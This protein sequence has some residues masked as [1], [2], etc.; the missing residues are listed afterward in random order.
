ML[1]IAEFKPTAPFNV[2]MLLLFPT[3]ET[4]N[5]VRT[6]KYDESISV[7]FNGSFQT[8]GGTE[9]NVNGIYSIEDTANIT[10]WYMPE[11]KSNCRIKVLPT[12]AEYDIV[13]EPE[14]INLRNQYLKFKVKR[15]KGYA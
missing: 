11:I 7:L 1:K 4:V 14:N 10:T 5:G 12:D 15:V 8:Y 13:G 9:T 3:Y 2:A 6:K